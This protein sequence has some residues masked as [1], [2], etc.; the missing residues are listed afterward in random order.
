MLQ[1]LSVFDASTKNWVIASRRIILREQIRTTY[2]HD[3]CNKLSPAPRAGCL[4]VWDGKTM[5]VRQKGRTK[6][7]L[8]GLLKRNFLLKYISSN[9]SQ[10]GLCIKSSS[11]LYSSETKISCTT[12]ATREGDGVVFVKIS[13]SLGKP[14]RP[15]LG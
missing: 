6:H 12:F 7:R 9:R 15:L 8:G 14:V 11:I 3:H 13:C 1:Q 4:R 10:I 2:L 5:T